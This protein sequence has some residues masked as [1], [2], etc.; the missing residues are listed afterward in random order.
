MVKFHLH[1]SPLEDTMGL[2]RPQSGKTASFLVSLS[3]YKFTMPLCHTLPVIVAAKLPMNARLGA[4]SG[5]LW[6]ETRTGFRDQG[7]SM[8]S[9][10]LI[11]RHGFISS[12][13][14][15]QRKNFHPLLNRQL[16]K[17]IVTYSIVVLS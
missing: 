12:F 10:R 5:F 9:Y 7:S 4:I 13:S 8:V 1:T 11:L 15:F 3:H 6:C 16:S 14:L 17:A 2:T